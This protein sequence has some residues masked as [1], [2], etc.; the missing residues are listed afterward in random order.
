M[1]ETVDL[2]GERYVSAPPS[3]SSETEHLHVSM[4]KMLRVR[5]EVMKCYH[6]N[7]TAAVDRIV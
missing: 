1:S 4:A 7:F 5:F 6:K 3:S 2:S